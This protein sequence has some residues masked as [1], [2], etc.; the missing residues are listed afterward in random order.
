MG[1]RETQ[2]KWEL[3]SLQ[4]AVTSGEIQRESLITTKM[5]PLMLEIAEATAGPGARMI[6]SRGQP[7]DMG[8]TLFTDLDLRWGGHLCLLLAL[9]PDRKPLHFDEEDGDEGD[10]E[11]G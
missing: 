10:G 3:M 11:Q 6:C 5:R 7:P 2:L 1:R 4:I 9:R 8:L